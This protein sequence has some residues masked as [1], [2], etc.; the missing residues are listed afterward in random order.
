MDLSPHDSHP[1]HF[2]TEKEAH[3]LEILVRHCQQALFQG[4]SVNEALS[5]EKLHTLRTRYSRFEDRRDSEGFLTGSTHLVTKVSTPRPYIHLLNNNHPREYGMYGSF[6]DQSGSG[7]SC[8]DSVIAGPITARKDSSYVPTAPRATDHRSFI[9]R[10]ETEQKQVKIWHVVPQ[11]GR[12]EEAYGTFLCEQGLGGVRIISERNELSSELLVFVPVDDPLEVWRLKLTNNASRSRKLSLFVSVNWGLDSYPGHYFDPRVVN[13]GVILEEL[14][15][16]IGLNNDKKNTHPRTGFLM[17]KDHFMGFDM[18]GEDFFGS[19]QFRIFPRAVEEGRCRG[20]MGFQPYLGLI[21]AMQ[22]DI[23]LGPGQEQSLDF[24]LGVTSPEIEKAPEQLAVYRQR[25]FEGRGIEKEPAEL[26]DSWSMMVSRHMAKTPDEEIDRFY[27]IWSKYQAKCSSRMLLSLDMVGYRDTLQY[28]MGINSFNPEFVAEHLPTV[29]CHQYE[30]G[31]S[32]RQFAKFKGAPHDL[33][34]YMDNCSWIAD[35]L[36]GYVKETGDE[37][38][39]EREEG[40][41][42]LENSRVETRNKTTIYEHALRSL[43]GL[44]GH[45]SAENGLCL[46]GHGDWN[47]SLDGIGRDGE[48]VSVWL[49]MALVFAAQRFRELALWRNDKQNVKLTD[50]II[51]EMTQTINRNAWDG[52]H[53]IYAFMPDGTPVGSMQNEEGKIHL[54]VNAWSLFNRVA[55]S[56]ERVEQ[57]LEAI[58]GLDTPLG[59]FLL[60]PPYTEKS[61]YV[62]RIA[63]IIPG[64]FENGSIYIHGQSFYIFGLTTLGK[65]DEAYRELKKILPE[66]TIPDIATGPLHE[67]SNFTTGKCHEHFGRNLYS[68]FTGSVNWLRKSLDHMFGLLADFDSLLIDP[69]I[70]SQWKSYE[71]VKLYRG[72]RVHACIQNPGGVNRGVGEASVDGEPLPVVDKR[73]RIPAERLKGREKA[74]LRVVLGEQSFRE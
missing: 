34:K 64:L 9:L 73:A 33:R 62:G 1:G 59:H 17:S 25:Y 4:K 47:D 48:G 31:T 3:E 41:F 71:V 32:M 56:A 27:N 20:S 10:E 46:I 30:N 65:G 15:C 22:F 23:Q 12:E 6:W 58:A 70:P 54:N 66:S 72:C 21:A 19:G 40:F 11:A 36:V 14:N 50:S 69:V 42:D 61:R 28:M 60:H 74:D 57:V 29:L 63:D 5:T 53:Y 45:R 13:Q 51:K 52:S 7:F 2:E 37:A 55:E 18:T 35:T 38:I 68:N 67:L 26:E 24:L 43:K 49:S 8:L 39:L 44:Y 16:L